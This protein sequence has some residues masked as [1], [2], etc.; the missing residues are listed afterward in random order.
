MAIVGFNFTKI[1][2]ERK[3]GA[4]GNVDI[5]NNVSVKGVESA[6]INI[7]AKKDKVVKFTFE[8]TSEYTPAIGSILFTGDLIYMNE[9]A[10]QDEIVKGWKKNKQIPKDV[11]SDIL[12]TILMRSNVQALVLSRDVNLPPPIP[13]PKVQR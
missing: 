10:K 1:L 2:V 4:S 3:S 12:N 9:Q 8:F 5:K 11:M 6:D 13:M 7:G